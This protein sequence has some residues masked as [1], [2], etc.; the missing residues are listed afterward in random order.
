MLL[1]LW[2]RAIWPLSSCGTLGNTCF[3][4]TFDFFSEFLYAG[5]YITLFTFS[6]THFNIW[7]C[8]R[9]CF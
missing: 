8:I 6:L 7:V 2:V 3:E 4:L 1:H 9:V 5:K